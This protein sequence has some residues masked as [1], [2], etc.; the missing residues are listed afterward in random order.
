MFRFMVPT[1]VHRYWDVTYQN[2]AGA[3]VEKLKNRKR[4]TTI[5]RWPYNLGLLKIHF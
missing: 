2:N 1:L 3:I 4:K 5:F